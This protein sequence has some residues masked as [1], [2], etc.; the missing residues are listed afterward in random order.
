MLQYDSSSTNTGRAKIRSPEK[1]LKGRAERLL[2]RWLITAVQNWVLTVL[3]ASTANI[4]AN[5]T[6]TRHPAR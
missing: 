1:D 2:V 4:G 5:I 6:A 3:L